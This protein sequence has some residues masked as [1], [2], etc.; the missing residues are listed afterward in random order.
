MNVIKEL[1]RAI[2]ELKKEKKFTLLIP[3]VRT[4]FVYTKKKV[5]N[6]N[7]V[8]GVDGRITIVNN[9]P[10]P[11]GKVKFGASDHLARLLLMVRKYNQN[12]RSAINF[13]FDKKILKIVKKIAQE[14]KIKI[15]VIERKREPKKYQLREKYSMPW[16]INYL[17]KRFKEIPQIFYETAG[18]G[19]EP[20]FVILGKEPREVVSI[21]K[22]ILKYL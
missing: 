5:K 3:E 21:I 14:R 15:G 2:N 13:K 9:K 6:I 16:K 10:Y 8:A 17:Y 7:D 1:V 19:K 18:L 12:Y 4:N 20:L 22:E 11:A